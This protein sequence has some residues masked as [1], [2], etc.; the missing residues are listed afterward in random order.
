MGVALCFGEAAVTLHFHTGCFWR[1]HGTTQIF[2]SSLS[3]SSA[4]CAKQSRG[5]HKSSS[6]PTNSLSLLPPAM[7]TDESLEFLF[8]F[9]F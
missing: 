4:D 2:I 5:L 1:Q 8:H 9:I 3:S 6:G 7:W